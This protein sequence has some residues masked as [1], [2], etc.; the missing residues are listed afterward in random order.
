MLCTACNTEVA[1]G[2]A[3]CPKCGAK[4]GAAPM[5][6]AVLP[7]AGAVTPADK[8]RA[9]QATGAVSTDAEK[10]LWHGGYS[11]KAMYGSWLLAAVATVVAAIVSV[12]V[13]T[14]I[15][16]LVAAAV[17]GALWLYLLGAYLIERWSVD[18]SLT[19]Q[20]LVHK[21]GI[22]RQATNRI[23]VI[24][25]DDVTFEQGIVERMFGVGTVK[26]LSSDKSHP[27][28][29]LRGIDGV[30]RVADLIDNARREE[31]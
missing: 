30:Q 9:A 10:E 17:V 21:K 23:E 29:F 1:S 18:Y 20:R 5:A 27:E 16:W 4:V 24:D 26:V 6:G 31:R 15:T 11:A 2:S 28:L 12:F 13:P 19:T 22:L 8:M 25:I 7:G 3:F 14:P